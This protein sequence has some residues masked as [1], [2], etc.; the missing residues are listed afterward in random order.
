MMEKVPVFGFLY[1]NAVVMVDRSDAHKRA[2]SVMQLK[3]VIKK[4]ISVVIAPEGTFNMT[5]HPLLELSDDVHGEE[6]CDK[7][8]VLVAEADRESAYLM[9]RHIRGAG[10]RVKVSHRD[11]PK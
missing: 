7:P 5:H 11:M 10:Y 4:G 3:S 1:R 2:K 9:A 8:F 6:P